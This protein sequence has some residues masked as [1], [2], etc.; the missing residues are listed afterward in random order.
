MGRGR[1][2]LVH[3]HKHAHRT[4]T[5]REAY[6]ERGRYNSWSSFQFQGETSLLLRCNGNV[7]IPFQMKHGNGPSSR[8]EE[9]KMGLFLSCIKGVKYRFEA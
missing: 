8:D 4:H 2:T 3:T 7:G 6:T 1:Q 9:G 5:N